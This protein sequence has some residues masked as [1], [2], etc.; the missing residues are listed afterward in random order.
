MSAPEH[1]A[2]PIFTVVSGHPTS[3][4]IAVIT[5]ILLA[6]SSVTPEPARRRSVGA[7]AHPAHSMN[8]P[9]IFGH[10]A[11]RASASR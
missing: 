11:W 2:S 6:A 1:A 8:A 3:Q 9:H 5:S 4:D 7:W 10:H